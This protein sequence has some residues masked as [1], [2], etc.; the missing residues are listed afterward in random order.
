MVI[1]LG[2]GKLNFNQIHSPKKWPCVISCPK[3]MGSVNTHM[4]EIFSY[5]IRHPL[6]KLI[7]TNK[8]NE[9]NIHLNNFKIYI[10][11]SFK[12]TS[13]GWSS[14]TK[15]GARDIGLFLNTDKTGFMRFNQDSFISSLNSKPLKLVDLLTYL[16]SYI[17]STKNNVNKRLDKVW[18]AIDRLTTE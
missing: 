5:F 1:N 2:E 13:S 12:Y 14:A 6:S 11:A 17:S 7:P 8:R 4:P 16:G 18:T 3:W 15:P 9:N 10:R